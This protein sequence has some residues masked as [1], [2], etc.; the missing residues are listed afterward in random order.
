MKAKG[1]E[2]TI[3]NWIQLGIFALT[4]GIGIQFYL[5]VMQA[6][7]DGPIT[8]A[9]PGGV[10]GFLPIGALI[11]WKRFFMTGSWDMIHPAAMV[12][13]GFAVVISLL[14]KKSFCSWFCP[15][16]TL[17]E[18][19]WKLGKKLF[20]KNYKIHPWI[21]YSLHSIKYILLA[22]FIYI[23]GSMSVD[24]INGFMQSPY[25]K[26]ADVKM[27]YFF[28]QMSL[29]TAV[30]LGILIAGSLL[31]RNFWCR[32]FCPYGAL[33]GIF[34]IFSPSKIY[35]NPQT[36]IHCEQCDRACPSHLLVSQ[37]NRID[38]PECTGCLDCTTVCPVEQTL[39]FQSIIIKK[40]EWKTTATGITIMLIFFGVVYI[41]QISGH[42]QSGVSKHEFA[43]R[44]KMIDAPEVAHPTYQLKHDNK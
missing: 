42:W 43:M 34:A 40:T 6:A 41:A 29:L 21:D 1:L 30:S 10:E 11:G 32:Y 17:S 35:R 26:M 36:C 44:L 25:Y 19:L 22:F 7:G 18:W 23:T 37:K 5:F 3:R 39:Q 14:F 16:G 31:V 12:I 20:G 33:M 27:L 4:M 8:I 38:S 9:R 15:V 28:T 24:A 13:L 2:W